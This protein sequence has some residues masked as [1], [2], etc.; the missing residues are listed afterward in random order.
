MVAFADQNS[1]KNVGKTAELWSPCFSC[2]CDR[3]GW[4][5]SKK[6]TLDAVS[7]K[8]TKPIFVFGSPLLLIPKGTSRFLVQFRS[9]RRFLQDSFILSFSLSQTWLTV[10][11]GTAAFPT[12]YTLIVFKY[13]TPHTKNIYAHQASI[14]CALEG[15]ETHLPALPVFPA[16][17]FQ[18]IKTR[19]V[20]MTKIRIVQNS[21]YK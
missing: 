16:I 3:G 10:R 20:R 6:R 12:R 9:C 18:K 14:F 15:K 5:K 7:I 17:L 21:G 1:E 19:C 11:H 4:N 13:G 2:K 8:Q